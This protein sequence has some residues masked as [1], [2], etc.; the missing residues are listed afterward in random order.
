MYNTA[1]FILLFIGFNSVSHAESALNFEEFWQQVKASNPSIKEKDALIK[2]IEKNPSLEIPAPEVSVSQMNENVPFFSSGKMQRTFEISQSI[3]F[4][5][6]FSKASE[7]KQANIQKSNEE[8]FLFQKELKLESYQVFLTY[9]KNQELK[10]ILAEKLTFYK[11]HLARAKSLQVTNQAYQVHL[12]DMGIEISSI[13]SELKIKDIDIAEIKSLLNRLRNHD[14]N[15]SLSEV[16]LPLLSSPSTDNQEGLLKHPAFALNQLEIEN[17]TKEKEMA[18]LDWA[19]DFNLK[20]RDIKSFDS[21]FTDGKEIMIGITLPFIFPW[22]RN[23]K[24]ESLSYKIKSQEYK[25]EQ[26]K[27]ELNQNYSTLENKLKEQWI[28]LSI[29]K[30]QN[31]PLVQKKINL[32]HKLTMTDMESLDAR[33]NAIDQLFNLKS[34]IIEEEMSYRLS[35][36]MLSELLN[37]NEGLQ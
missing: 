25:G 11:N 4:I 6:K 30:E 13:K 37:S 2:S 23:A 3:P 21:H 5:T 14:I 19:P 29:Y 10:K 1:F 27:T 9:A 17:M 15:E 12:L 22:Q 20:L 8:N 16:E 36:F 28:L 7:V 33:R 35:G 32:T 18:K 26:I 34:K 24:T 31:L